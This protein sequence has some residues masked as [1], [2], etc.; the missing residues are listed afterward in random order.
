MK[1]LGHAERLY[2]SSS[3]NS[4][5]PSVLRTSFICCAPKSLVMLGKVCIPGQTLSPSLRH[6]VVPF[7]LRQ[8]RRMR[9]G[10]GQCSPFATAQRIIASLTSR[11]H[12]QQQ[13]TKKTHSL[14]GYVTALS[15]V[16]LSHLYSLHMV[17]SQCQAALYIV[18]V[19]ASV[20]DVAVLRFA[21][22]TPYQHRQG[23]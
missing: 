10:N 3:L 22:F 2:L 7:V 16:T 8:P 23:I 15:I 20:R 12:G 18:H 9:S 13:W 21:C 5:V 1:Y 19:S 11:E 4:T 14:H 6:C 17:V